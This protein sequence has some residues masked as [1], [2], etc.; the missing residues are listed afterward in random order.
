MATATSTEVL[1]CGCI[2]EIDTPELATRCLSQCETHLKDRGRIG[3][4]PK[5]LPR[6]FTFVDWIS[7]N[8]RR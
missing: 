1:D 8:V 3:L 2:W 5:P 6:G 7:K 4:L